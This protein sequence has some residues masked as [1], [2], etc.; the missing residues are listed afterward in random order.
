M[1]LTNKQLIDSLLNNKNFIKKCNLS[2]DK[3]L[4]EEIKN[5][6]IVLN[7]KDYCKDTIL[8]NKK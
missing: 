3:K 5:F 8:Q 1:K 7:K 6:K 4:I 2:V